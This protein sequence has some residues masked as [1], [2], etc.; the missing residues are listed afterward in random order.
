MANRN[1][2]L[3]RA[4]REAL[5]AVAKRKGTDLETV[6]R[7]LFEDTLAGPKEV[8][9]WNAPAGPGRIDLDNPR[10]VY[11]TTV[12]DKDQTWTGEGRAV[13]QLVVIDKKHEVV[14]GAVTVPT[15]LR[16]D[17]AVV[18]YQPERVTFLDWGDLRG[19]TFARVPAAV[20]WPSFDRATP[21]NQPEKWV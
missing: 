20:G 10:N 18:L 17:L 15:G 3:A 5:E 4:A 19:N 13:S 1:E 9:F 21:K 12:G 14:I 6:R 2:E 16:S 11:V 8:K 7:A